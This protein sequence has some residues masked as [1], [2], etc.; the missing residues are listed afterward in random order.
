MYFLFGT[1]FS[2]NEE[3]DT[4]FNVECVLLGRNFNFLGGYLVATAHYLSVTTGQCLLLVVAAGYRSLL[5][6]HTFS[7]NETKHI[8]L[9]RDRKG[10]KNGIGR[11]G[12]RVSDF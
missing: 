12:R 11:L 10:T 2:R 3:I 7:M 8:I 1:K 6:V 5:L 9:F 4:C